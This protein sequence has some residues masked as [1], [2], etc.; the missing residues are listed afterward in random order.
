METIG[1]VCGTGSWAG[2]KPGDPD[3]HSI[4]TATPA[5]GGIDVTWTYPVTNPFAVAHTILYRASTNN[6]DNAVRHAIVNGNFF[7][8]KITTAN[9]HTYYYWIQFVS[10]HGTYGEVIGP[11][12]AMA[13]PL[14]EDVIAGLTNKIDSGLLAQSLK[15]EIA[16]IDY[17][18]EGITKEANYRRDDFEAL[19]NAINA[20]H[21]TVDDVAAIVAEEVQVRASE[22]SS[23]AQHLTTVQS[24]LGDDIASVQTNLETFITHANNELQS[25]GALYTVKVDVNG[26]VGGFG[27]YNDGTEVEAGFDVD[28]FWVG[29]TQANKRKPFI[30]ENGEVFID[31]A[32]INKLTFSKLRDESGSFIVKDGKIKADYI[33]MGVAQIREANIQDASITTAKIVDASVNTLKIGENAVTIPSYATGGELTG[34]GS[35]LQSVALSLNLAFAGNVLILWNFKQHYG[36]NAGAGYPRWGF[37]VRFNGADVLSRTGMNAPTDYPTGMVSVYAP[38]GR[39]T[40]ILDW[41]GQRSGV[42]AV[43]SLLVMG[44]MR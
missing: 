14:I 2:P 26:L 35:F 15:D 8:D 38:S 28:R 7:Y 41:L 9:N 4:L 5:F 29:R 42:R 43:G 21:A 37:R 31:E 44:V 40:I 20:L 33:T 10:I 17:L 18:E 32:A 27:V 6:F 12:S 13:R 1:Y 23:L 25:I 30:I 16:R 34:N 22:T 3:N 36:G 11:A 19:G 24:A 39:H